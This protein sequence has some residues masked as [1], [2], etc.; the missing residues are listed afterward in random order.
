MTEKV[1]LQQV[2]QY[3]LPRVRQKLKE[4][5]LPFG[6]MNAVVSPGQRVLLKPNL[7][8]GKPPEAAVTTHPVIVQA[9]A[10]LVIEAG[11]TV[12]V[13]DSPGLGLFE[14]VAEKTGIAE[15]VR[16]V[17]G[18]LVPFSNTR[19]VAADGTFRELELA[20]EY[21]DA[22]IVINLPKLKTHEM[23]TL[24]CAVK[25]LYGAVVGPAKAGLHLSAGHSRELFAGLLLEI[26]L[27]RPVALTIVDAV[28]AMEGDGPSSGTPRNLGLLMA[29][30]N[31]VAIDTVAARL[32]DIPADLL[33]VK[34]VAQQRGLVGT[35]LDQ[36][37]IIGAELSDLKAV[38]A[39]RLPKGLDTQFGIPSFLKG[40]LRNQ[41]SPLPEADPGLCT[42][43]GICR[44]ACPPGAISINKNAL[45]VSSGRCIRCWCCRE[46]CP[47]NALNIKQSMLLKLSTK[48]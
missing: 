1:S 25:N 6:G 28:V 22:D 13:G 26:A 35:E 44:D 33:P 21:L 41:L 7:L 34:K 20:S 24:T 17:N 5:L 19:R 23:M 40:L 14:R 47:H 4:L 37:N 32:A 11:G 2:D 18:R 30:T 8:S 9:V 27:A 38:P 3:Q 46:L 36:V 39:F 29:G 12:L 10:E 43:C 16:A 42:L 15:A 48:L 31:M 45:K